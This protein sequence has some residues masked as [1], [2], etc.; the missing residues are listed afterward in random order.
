MKFGSRV[1][2]L[3]GPGWEI[4]VRDGQRVS[5]GSTVIARAARQQE[6]L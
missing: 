1:D 6:P 5:A 2:V 3:V 4:V